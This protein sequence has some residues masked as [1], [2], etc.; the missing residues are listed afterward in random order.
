MGVQTAETSLSY[1]GLG[2]VCLVSLVC[3]CVYEVHGQ[4]ADGGAGDGV[5]RVLSRITDD[6]R[7]GLCTHPAALHDADE[8]GALTVPRQTGQT[9]STQPGDA[10]QIP[11]V[12]IHN[13]VVVMPS[14]SA[15]MLFVGWQE[16]HPA[17]KN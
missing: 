16:G 8:A 4:P 11:V 3:V 9:Y 17:C 6:P 13:S 5:Q 12:K 15:L 10:S 1:D 14:I 2:C 7:A